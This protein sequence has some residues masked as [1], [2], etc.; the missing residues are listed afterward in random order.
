MSSLLSNPTPR[1]IDAGGTHQISLRQQV[2]A[3]DTPTQPTA[4]HK[5]LMDLHVTAN[6]GLLNTNLLP[7]HALTADDFRAIDPTCHRKNH[8][9]RNNNVGANQ[10]VGSHK[11]AVPM[12]TSKQVSARLTQMG[13]AMRRKNEIYRAQVAAGITDPERDSDIV[14]SAVAIS[15]KGFFRGNLKPPYDGR[16]TYR[17]DYCQQDPISFGDSVKQHLSTYRNAWTAEESDNI[18]RSMRCPYLTQPESVC[19]S[20]STVYRVDYMPNAERQE[21]RTLPHQ[22]NLP[23]LGTTFAYSSYTYEDPRRTVSFN[24][25]VSKLRDPH[26]IL[27]K[28]YTPRDSYMQSLC[29][30]AAAG[31]GTTQVTGSSSAG[32]GTVTKT[33]STARRDLDRLRAMRRETIRRSVD[34]HTALRSSTTF[35]MEQNRKVVIPGRKGTG[36]RCAAHEHDDYISL[37]RDHFVSSEGN[38]SMF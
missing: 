18:D 11:A 25:S 17:F 19:K 9:V 16:S 34:R 26:S 5:R 3:A 1:D 6:P 4:S 7:P 27:E 32:G 33:V 31:E 10:G 30:D 15:S 20:R 12:M 35:E 14:D 37:P 24:P 21:F 2:L 38:R 22:V 8:T 29:E 36:Y 23:E 13:T 28:T